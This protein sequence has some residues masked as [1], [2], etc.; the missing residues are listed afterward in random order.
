MISMFLDDFNNLQNQLVSVRRIL[1]YNSLQPEEKLAHEEES[2][3]EPPQLIIGEWPHKGRVEYRSVSLK[4]EKGEGYALRDV[5]FEAPPTSKIGI[6]GRTGAGKSSI[7][8]ALFRLTEIDSC[9][10]IYID[11]V[12]TRNVDLHTL[13]SAIAYIPQYPFVF[14]GSIRDNLDPDRTFTD[15]DIMR[16]LDEVRLGDFVRSLPYGL[17]TDLTENKA[18]FSVG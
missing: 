11:R 6:V 8:Q 5:S 17:S 16:A 12:D 14:A 3:K 4:Y 2:K 10:H 1:D 18:V 7:L 9:G 13:R 15:P